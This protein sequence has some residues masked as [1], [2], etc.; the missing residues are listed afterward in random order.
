MKPITRNLL[1][2]PVVLVRAAVITCCYLVST[3]CVR[4]SDAALWTSEVAARL[5][6]WER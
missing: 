1:V 6:A 5:P 3:A 4:V 2:T